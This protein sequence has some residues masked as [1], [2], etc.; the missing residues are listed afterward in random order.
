MDFEFS[1]VKVT[2]FMVTPGFVYTGKKS[3]SYAVQLAGNVAIPN[4]AA[5]IE[6][7][8]TVFFEY[9]SDPGQQES[10]TA[11]ATL[12]KSGAWREVHFFDG[13]PFVLKVCLARSDNQSNAT[14]FRL[15]Q[16]SELRDLIPQVF[17]QK[18]ITISGCTFDIIL[19]EKA[20]NTLNDYVKKKAPRTTAKFAKFIGEEVLDVASQH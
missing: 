11:R 19:A 5:F 17:G 4:Q 16:S 3:K 8:C 15:S 1:K 7:N 12:Q 20:G 10:V 2:D 6:S 14:E 18:C 13:L 9:I